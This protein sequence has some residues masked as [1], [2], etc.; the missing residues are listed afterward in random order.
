MAAMG[1]VD[2]VLNP[3][4]IGLTHCGR[5][6]AYRKVSRTAVVVLDALIT[7]AE[8]DLVEH[9]LKGSDDLHVSLDAQEIGLGIPLRGEFLMAGLLVLVKWDGGELE[10]AG[11]AI[12]DGTDHQA[13]GHGEKRFFWMLMLVIC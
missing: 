11:S 2:V 13:L 5:F 7:A 9:V 12:L 10:L 3:Q 4:E 8:L 1:A 6:L